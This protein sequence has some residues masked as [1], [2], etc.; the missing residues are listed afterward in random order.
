MHH[1]IKHK[2]HERGFTL[3][4]MAIAMMIVALLLAPALG[5]YFRYTS[6]QDREQTFNAMTQARNA[7]GGFRSI[8]GRYPCPADPTLPPD[9]L[10][11]GY[12]EPTCSG[13]GVD[14]ATSVRSDIVLANPTILI[15]AVPFRQM[16][17]M[18]DDA[19]DGYGNRLTYAVMES[20]TDPT[21]FDPGLGGISV[22]DHNNQSV[23][24]PPDSA[25]IVL[26][27][28]NKNSAGAYTRDGGI[29]EGACPGGTLETENCDGDEVFRVASAQSDYDDLTVFATHIS[30]SEWQYSTADVQDIHLRTADK[31]VMGIAND[32]AVLTGTQNAEVLYP[33]SG[34]EAVARADTGVVK[35]EL[36]CT[37]DGA[38][39]F[40]PDTLAGFDSSEANSEM[41]G[42]GTGGTYC[43]AG[44]YAVAVENGGVSCVPELWFSCPDG[45][46]FA[47][48][49]GDGDLQ[50]SAEPDPP[51]ASQG[52]TLSCGA[53]ET[54]PAL[55][56][57][58]S[59]YFYQGE[60]HMIAP[61]NTAALDAC[62][63][64]DACL[65]AEIASLNNAARSSMDCEATSG[66]ANT[67][68]IRD[69]FECDA[70]TWNGPIGRETGDFRDPN[71][72]WGDGGP[73]ETYGPA[74]TPG[75][76][77][78]VDAN[79]DDWTHDCWCRE[80][81]RT[82]HNIT[83]G[84][85]YTGSY[86]AVDWHR[87]PQTGDEW[88]ED[89][90]VT[91]DIDCAC[92]PST[93]DQ[94]TDCDDYYGV[95]SGSLTGQVVETYETTCP[96]GPTGAPFFNPVPIATDA[97]ACTCPAKTRL[98]DTDPCPAGF[99]NSFTFDSNNYNDVE[100]VSYNE[101][102]CPPPTPGPIN[103]ATGADA[104][105]WTGYSPV[106]TE[107]CNC[108]NTRPPKN[109]TL[110]CPAGYTGAGITYEV[111]WLC[112]TGTWEPQADWTQIGYDCSQCVWQKPAGSPE[113]KDVALGSEIGTG[114]CTCGD[115]GLCYESVGGGYF[116]VYTGCTC[117]AN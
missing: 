108:D 109:E 41:A 40:D 62:A 6:F 116:D 54:V 57:T 34:L 43:P 53:A 79:N 102:G 72:V 96:G 14:T 4:E 1:T 95:P 94:Y 82:R 84:P 85:G 20:M 98:I 100:T 19:L 77:M 99:T 80:D 55:A 112:P 61:L 10:D 36:I 47:G 31:M 25:H 64:G 45:T 89:I 76:P 50:C 74:Y 33:G 73:A 16:N 110:P 87:C 78:S 101:W 2:Q 12:E 83:C 68:L 91:S 71:G 17:M 103:P 42:V 114:S 69:E 37:D 48:L 30:I 75:A 22:V 27:S 56:S 117:T 59:A 18:E 86:S 90:Y 44:E 81:Y 5:L 65:D 70:G 11:Y 97:S 49:D 104:G 67:Q 88:E 35:S 13:G 39:C 9:D 38:N 58:Q 29:S 7:I 111:E 60:C 106:H 23:I 92:A 63:G 52:V 66:A 21:T 93:N 51:C 107:V 46:F 32:T 3:V 24:D 26:L 113:L 105:S 28:H 115:T 8:Y 15:G